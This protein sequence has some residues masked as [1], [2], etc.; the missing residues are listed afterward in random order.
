MIW[1]GQLA[2]S[3]KASYQKTPTLSR[4]GNTMIK[5]ANDTL[6]LGPNLLISSGA[7]PAHN[8]GRQVLPLVTQQIFL[9]KEVA[10]HDSRMIISQYPPL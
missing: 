8:A 10:K 4:V 3:L 9:M 2:S 7:P 6:R 1:V 5:V